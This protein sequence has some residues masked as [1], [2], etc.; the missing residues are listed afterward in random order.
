MYFPDK[1]YKCIKTYDN[2]LSIVFTNFYCGNLHYSGRFYHRNVKFIIKTDFKLHNYHTLNKTNGNSF[3]QNDFK[4][5]GP[6]FKGLKPDYTSLLLPSTTLHL[7]RNLCRFFSSNL[8]KL[9]TRK[10]GISKIMK[11]LWPTDTRSKVR[12]LFSMVFLLSAKLS[13]ISVPLFLSSLINSIV[14]A[15]TDSFG[16]IPKL[17]MVGVSFPEMFI[18]YVYL[19]GFVFSKISSSLFNELRNSL[20][21]TVT[22][23]SARENASKMFM[24]IHNLDVDFLIQSKSGEVSAVFSRGIRAISQILRIT[25]FQVVPVILEFSL[26]TALLCYKVGPMIATIT[27]LTV[28]LYLLFTTFVTKRR[29]IIRKEMADADRKASG[30]FLD[31]ITNA[32]AVRYYNAQIKELE[33]YSNQQMDYEKHSVDVQKSLAFLNFG[34]QFIFNCGLFL[35]LFLTLGDI[36]KGLAQFDNFIIVNTL[37]FQIGVPLNM[38]GTMYR[39]VKLSFIDLQKFLD[40]VGVKPKVYELPD[41]KDLALSQG[42]IEFKNVNYFYPSTETDPHIILDDFSLTIP[43]GKTVAIVGDSGSGKSTIFKL[44]FRFYDPNSG[45]ILI[46]DQDIKNV[47]LKSLRN[48]LGIVP[49]DVVL[50]N[51]SIA[52][53]ISYGK[54]DASLD[55]VMRAA[56]LA[57]IHDTIMSFPDGYDTIVGERGM[58]L[59]GGEKQRIGIARCFLKDPQILLFD[60]ATSSLDFKAESQIIKTFKEMGSNKT[61]VM[62]AHRLSSMLIADEIVVFHKGKIVEM[63]TPVE[64]WNKTGYFRQIVN[65]FNLKSKTDDTTR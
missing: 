4:T 28:V 15:P 25:V 8:D 34:Q 49:Q 12:I 53:N 22:E 36:T 17:Q 52:F 9:P 40:L 61:T 46:D 56:K 62:I 38:I 51:E 39:E 30:L 19:F 18:P 23:R 24:N 33:R 3:I 6:Q 11:L 43:P 7:N 41:A 31:S 37:L 27:S 45:S 64:L 21:S 47:T 57:G 58:M 65:S 42:K 16:I 60:E 59:S 35:S 63:G 10:Y 2:R 50:F 26:V 14:K 13:L 44:L 29:M 1:L 32:E 20:F 55:D 48:T 5:F 54:P